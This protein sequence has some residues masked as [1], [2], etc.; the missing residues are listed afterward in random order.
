PCAISGFAAPISSSMSSVGGWNVEARDSV[1]RSAPASNTV[2]GTPRCARLAAAAS[3]TGP[4]PAISTR[5]SIVIACVVRSSH[6]RN[7]GLLDDAAP[8]A[9]LRDDEL[10]QRLGAG[11]DRL[12]ALVD[13]ALAHVRI[14]DRRLQCRVELIDDR[15]RRA[16]RRQ[17]R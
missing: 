4:A 13:E 14:V 6:R 11:R 2:T 1:V 9:G 3:P 5:S 15:L 7:A 16:R 17:Q 8:L 10:L 12:S